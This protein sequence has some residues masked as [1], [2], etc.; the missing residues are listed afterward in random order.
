MSYNDNI[1]NNEKKSLHSLNSQSKKNASIPLRINFIK[2]ILKNNTLE[3]MVNFNE[4][5]TE[6][7]IN[8]KNNK[9]S[10]W[11]GY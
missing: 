11:N 4:N 9:A 7:Y 2:D 5:D 3:P 6:Y 8:C 10:A 1:S